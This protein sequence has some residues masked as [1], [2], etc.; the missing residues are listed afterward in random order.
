VGVSGVEP[1]L[2]KDG[3][4]S[5]AGRR[6]NT[7]VSHGAAEEASDSRTVVGEAERGK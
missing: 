7:V 5:N 4:P 1:Q 2:G 6:G 3:V